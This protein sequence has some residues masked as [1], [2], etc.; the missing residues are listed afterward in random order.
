[1]GVDW[2]PAPDVSARSKKILQGLDMDWIDPKRIY[3]FRSHGSKARAYARIWGLSKIWQQALHTRP[4]YVIEV[5]AEKFDKLSDDQKDEVLIHEL[6]HIP[7]TFSGSLLPH[8]RKGKKNFH[9][10]VKDHIHRFRK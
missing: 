6:T 1:M 2:I 3:Y 4:S 10:K 5:L 8:F 7:K 9:R